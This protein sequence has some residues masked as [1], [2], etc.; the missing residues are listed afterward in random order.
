[1]QRNVRLS[2]F[3]CCCLFVVVFIR[4]IFILYFIFFLVEID[5]FGRKI[6]TKVDN[7]LDQ[8]YKIKEDGPEQKK[9]QVLENKEK[10]KDQL[11][12]K[13]PNK[14]R[15]EKV[16][17]KKKEATIKPIEEDD[18]GSTDEEYEVLY[19]ENNMLLFF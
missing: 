3:I 8:F 11:R 18:G 10:Q 2:C 5:E 12:K 14:V 7:N 15:K 17:K 19:F 4:S 6:E 9:G 1:M 13:N 16:I